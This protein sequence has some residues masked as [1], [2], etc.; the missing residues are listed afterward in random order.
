M[1]LPP[2][3]PCEGLTGGVFPAAPQILGVLD[4]FAPPPPDP[5]ATAAAGPQYAPPPPPPAELIE[6]KVDVFP[7]APGF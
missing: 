3:F 2:G 7:A 6:E 5:P 1:A 4:A